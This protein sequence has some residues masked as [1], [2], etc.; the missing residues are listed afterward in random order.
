MEL[1]PRWGLAEWPPRFEELERSGFVGIRPGLGTKKYGRAALELR[2]EVPKRMRPDPW[3]C[4]RAAGFWL[5]DAAGY[6]AI[7]AQFLAAERPQVL[8]RSLAGFRG[9]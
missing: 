6:F 8:G 4:E 5:E 1:Q 3:A 2:P 9:S 7:D